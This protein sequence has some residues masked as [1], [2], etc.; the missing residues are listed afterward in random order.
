MIIYK[1]EHESPSSNHEFYMKD[2]GEK[3]LQFS[4]ITDVIGLFD[5]YDK[6][7]FSLLKNLFT[8]FTPS[9]PRMVSPPY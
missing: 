9:A 7:V 8:R 6:H 2:I 3:L 5:L 1:I 4:F